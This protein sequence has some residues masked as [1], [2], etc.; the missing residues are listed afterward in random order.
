MQVQGSIF[1]RSDSYG[2]A[3]NLCLKHPFTMIIA[4]PTGC[5]KT[6]WVLGKLVRLRSVITDV[7]PQRILYFYGSSFQPIFNDHASHVEFIYGFPSPELM[8]SSARP[9]SP[10]WIIIDDLMEEASNSKGIANLFTRGSHHDN[11][12]VIFL[13]QNLFAKGKEFRTISLNAH[14]LVLFK[15]PR[16]RS[17]IYS[18][19]RQIFPENTK[20]LYEAYA[21][22]TA[23]S[24]YSYLFIDLKPDTSEKARILTNLFGENGK[25][26]HP[27]VYVP[28]E[29]SRFQATR[30]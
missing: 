22:A 27:I 7:P 4:G 8:G 29:K 18:I 14:Y 1:Q 26:Q 30:F 24:P 28:H 2:E 21:D 3:I 10:K 19:G 11:V 20:F 9:P 25:E 23:S 13:V 12:S 15:N 5:G 16:D 17:T 6:V